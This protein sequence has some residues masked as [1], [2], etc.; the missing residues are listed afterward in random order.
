MR[1]YKKLEVWK[2]SHEMYMFIK[3]HVASKFPKERDMK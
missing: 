1:D 3:K 2:K